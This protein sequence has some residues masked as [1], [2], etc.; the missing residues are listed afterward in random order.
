LARWVIGSIAHTRGVAVAVV[1]RVKHV[2][3][4]GVDLEQSSAVTE[5]LWLELFLS[6]ERAFL[7]SMDKASRA[8]FATAIF[9]V[10]EAF[11]KFQFPHTNEWLNFQDVELNMSI[12]A[13]NCTLKTNRPLLLGGGKN[14]FPGNFRLENP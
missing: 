6:E 10:K 3:A 12:G 14:V 9:S 11:Y 8:R 1:A 2:S 13:T 4:I 5:N 7:Q